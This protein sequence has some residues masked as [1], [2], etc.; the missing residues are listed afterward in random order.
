MNGL[1]I[2]VDGRPQATTKSRRPSDSFALKAGRVARLLL[3]HP[4]RA[5]QVQQLAR[6][7]Q[8]SIGLASRAKRTLIE[9]AYA[10]DRDGLIALRDP[11]ALL[12]S[13]EARYSA[14]VS[15]MSLYVMQ[16]VAEAEWA[17]AQWCKLQGVE[18]ALADFSGAWRVAP[19]VRYK[20]ACI[21]VHASAHRD[22]VADLGQALGAKPAETGSNFVIGVTEDEA[23]FWAAQA[24]DGVR[25]LSPLQ[26]Y[27][28]LRSQPGRGQEA[29]GEILR[30]AL[31]PAFA[32]FGSTGTPES[33]RK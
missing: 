16:D 10:E 13:W 22:V 21:Y 12:Q 1:A 25:V 9:Q 4:Q 11:R 24:V 20:Q 28:D 6:E 31:E 19:M 7:G 26:L 15:R 3:L 5:W 27:L 2:H 32:Q 8:I 14:P 18:Y 23:V 29:A 33:T 17:A 30:R